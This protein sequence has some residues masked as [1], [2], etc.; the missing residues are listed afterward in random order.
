MHETITSTQ[1]IYDGRVVKLDVHNVQLPNG[2]SSKREVIRHP[3]A[4]A[5]VALNEHNEVL[6]VRQFRLPVGE[7][8][9][10]N[11]CWHP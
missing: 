5:I 11:S 6:M 10:G 7:D 1:N 8:H 9:H 4:V 3:G 2:Q